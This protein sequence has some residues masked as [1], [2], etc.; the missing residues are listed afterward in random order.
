MLCVYLLMTLCTMLGSFDW[1]CGHVMS[2]SALGQWQSTTKH[3]CWI[4][5]LLKPLA[6]W[7]GLEL[8]HCFHSNE[9]EREKREGG[10]E[11][12]RERGKEE[13]YQNSGEARMVSKK[14]QKC[15]AILDLLTTDSPRFVL[16]IQLQQKTCM[17]EAR[18]GEASR[19]NR[20][21]PLGKFSWCKQFR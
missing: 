3:H 20:C 9:I 16:F 14:W 13:A 21:Y 11:G 18:S 6:D 15:A 7:W 2:P 1:S 19:T 8:T 4:L 12:G 5:R 10:R 17:T